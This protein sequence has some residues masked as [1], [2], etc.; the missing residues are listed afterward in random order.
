MSLLGH[1]ASSSESSKFLSKES[2]YSALRS[3]Y[4]VIIEDTNSLKKGFQRA[5]TTTRN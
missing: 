5:S 2:L 4:P 3:V 1:S